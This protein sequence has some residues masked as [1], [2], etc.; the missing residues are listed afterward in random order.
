MQITIVD[1]FIKVVRVNDTFRTDVGRR[2]QFLNIQENGP[3]WF[4]NSC[5]HE[6]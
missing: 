3:E 1:G 5:G 6:I 2:S 4:F